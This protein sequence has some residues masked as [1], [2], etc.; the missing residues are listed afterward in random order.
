MKR[1]YIIGT[2]DTKFKELDFVKKCLEKTGLPT[3]LVDV[4][5]TPHANPVDVS[6]EEIA[7]ISSGSRQDLLEKNEW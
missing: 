2:A 4:G 7:G 5:T 3:L 6:A 1:A